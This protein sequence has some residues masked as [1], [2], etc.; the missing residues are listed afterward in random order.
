MDMKA[1]TDEDLMARTAKGDRQ[2]FDTLVKRHL[3][4]VY[5]LS[6]G[7][8]N[9][10]PDAEDVAQDV[11]TRV[12]IYAP[13]WR[14]GEAA[15][16]TW[17]HRIT[18]NCCYDHLRKR[19]SDAKNTEIP[20]ELASTE[21]DGEAKYADR[22]KN[23]RIRDALAQLPE[24][25][26]MAVTLCYLQEMTNAEAAEVMEIHIKALEG[27]LVRARRSLRP[28]LEEMREGT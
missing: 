26:R 17:L 14:A 25:Q 5:F 22:Q 9:K 20:D 2:A 21:K 13:R 11:F 23:A 19:G 3:Q 6:R 15:F 8:L 18:M 1:V 10:K 12:W 27:L 28:Q 16:T 4:R 24:R 7:M